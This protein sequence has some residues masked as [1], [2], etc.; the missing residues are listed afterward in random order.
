[1]ATPTVDAD[2]IADALAKVWVEAHREFGP[3]ENQWTPGEVREYLLR[4]DAARN[5][6]QVVA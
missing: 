1:M 4:L 2:L 3:D 5:D 6:P